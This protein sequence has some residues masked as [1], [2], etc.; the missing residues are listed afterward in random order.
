MV[1]EV[2]LKA[3]ARNDEGPSDRSN[4]ISCIFSIDCGTFRQGM[5]IICEG[6]PRVLREDLA[7]LSN[8][9]RNVSVFVVR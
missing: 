2:N 3:R 4:V 5:D 8:K 7:C 6:F 1:L 9:V